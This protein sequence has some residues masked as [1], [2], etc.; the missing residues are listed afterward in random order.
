MLHHVPGSDAADAME[1]AELEADE[2][3]AGEYAPS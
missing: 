3:M 2:A 1:A